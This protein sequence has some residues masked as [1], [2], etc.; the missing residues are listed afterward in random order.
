MILKGLG[1]LENF[2]ASSTVLFLHSFFIQMRKWTPKNN[3]IQLQND[4]SQLLFV[5]CELP[6]ALADNVFLNT[7]LLLFRWLLKPRRM[8]HEEQ[9]T[10]T[11]AHD[12]GHVLRLGRVF[13]VR[14]LIDGVWLVTDYSK[15]NYT[16]FLGN[17]DCGD[18]SR[19]LVA[20][21]FLASASFDQFV[22][23]ICKR[24]V[25]IEL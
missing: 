14:F 12:I 11:T 5:S 1:I 18:D 21:C 19:L 15:S 6:L 20:I 25:V 24:I 10:L 17:C 9:S 2:S 3:D 16:R 7:T 13:R 4:N 8:N 23:A 22:P